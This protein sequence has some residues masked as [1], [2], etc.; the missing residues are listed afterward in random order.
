MDATGDGGVRIDRVWVG[1]HVHVL[2]L[3]R[4]QRAHLPQIQVGNAPLLIG[5]RACMRVRYLVGARGGV[6]HNVQARGSEACVYFRF[7]ECA[8]IARFSGPRHVRRSSVWHAVMRQSR[9]VMRA[10]MCSVRLGQ[11]CMYPSIGV[12]FDWRGVV[13]CASSVWPCVT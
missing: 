11:G 13:G 3:R 12:D 8:L 2:A 10:H 4:A 6:L 1:L 9:L 7:S 5:G